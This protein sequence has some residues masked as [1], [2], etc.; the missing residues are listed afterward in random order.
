MAIAAA[1]N[2]TEAR[3]RALAA[4]IFQRVLTAFE[5]VDPD[6][7]EAEESLGTVTIRLPDGSRWILSVQPPARQIW[8][9]VA[10]LGRAYHFDFNPAD[11][12]WRDSKDPRSELLTKLS[13]L[14]REVAG[15]DIHF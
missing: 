13:A 15:V 7:A 2:L 8:L 6:V 11:E 10:S 5:P 12:S 4:G 3:F 1:Q 9:A 14:L